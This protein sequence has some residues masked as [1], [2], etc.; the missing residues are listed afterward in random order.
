MEDEALLSEK[1]AEKPKARQ[2]SSSLGFYLLIVACVALSL[3]VVGF[4]IAFRQLQNRLQTRPQTPTLDVAAPVLSPDLG[5]VPIERLIDTTAL[6]ERGNFEVSKN[7]TVREC[8]S[9]SLR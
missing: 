3:T 5:F 6:N 9:I 4:G 8:K 2:R 1:P 7:T